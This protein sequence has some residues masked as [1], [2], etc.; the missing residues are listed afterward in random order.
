MFDE[1]RQLL[2]FSRFVV[3]FEIISMEVYSNFVKPYG[4]KPANK[5]SRLI[6][7]SDC[8]FS[9]AVVHVAWAWVE[10]AVGRPSHV[11]MVWTLEFLARQRSSDSIRENISTQSIVRITML[12]LNSTAWPDRRR[13][14][15]WWC[16]IVVCECVLTFVCQRRQSSV[17]FPRPRFRH[18]SVSDS[19]NS[20]QAG[21]YL[22]MSLINWSV[23]F[24]W[25]NSCL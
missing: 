18:S 25:N 22:N 19:P 15:I 1:Q 23:I 8:Q 6:K 14:A 20:K 2:D 12:H 17:N 5:F 21:R 7:A 13:T 9:L 11:P 24:N 16:M 4:G 3:V 10:I